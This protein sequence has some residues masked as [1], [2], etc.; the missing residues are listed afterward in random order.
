MPVSTRL[1]MAI[2][3]G[4]EKALAT[5]ME[6]DQVVGVHGVKSSIGFVSSICVDIGFVW[7][8]GCRHD[9]SCLCTCPLGH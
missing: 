9:S 3:H 5:I 8:W 2:K 4:D 1:N 6:K 7:G